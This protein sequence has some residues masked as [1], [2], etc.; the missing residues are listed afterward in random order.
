MVRA[1]THGTIK[2]LLPMVTDL[3]EVQQFKAILEEVR[4]EVQREGVDVPEHIPVGVM[5]EVPAAALMAAQFAQHVDFFSIGTNDLTQYV[6]AVDR[7]NDLVANLFQELHPAV[8]SMIRQTVIAAHEAGIPV[9]VCGEMAG[10][11]RATAVLVGLGVDE[12]STVPSALPEVKRVIRAMM[13]D[14]A[15]ALAQAALAQQDAQAVRAM[16]DTWLKK[17]GCGLL[18][19]L[20]D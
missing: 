4:C 20:D 19:F 17:H 15:K 18:R 1:S 9:S 14:E 13:L 6:L 12:L 3:V 11:P 8:L 5:I 7:G 16:V 10:D 2:M